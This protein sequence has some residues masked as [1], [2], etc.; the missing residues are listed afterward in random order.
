MRYWWFHDVQGEL[1]GPFF[2]DGDAERERDLMGYNN[3]QARV[4]FT[5]SPN[6]D[7]AFINFGR[8]KKG[9]RTSRYSPE[10]YY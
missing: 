2:S 10:Q 6:R 5:N 7:S 9:P 8:T 3:D 4:F 1:H